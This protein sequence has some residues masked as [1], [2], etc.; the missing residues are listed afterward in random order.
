MKKLTLGFLALATALATPTVASATTLQFSGGVNIKDNATD[1]GNGDFWSTSTST[2]IGPLHIS[3][4]ASNTAKG[5]GGPTTVLGSQ[6]PAGSPLVEPMTWN[7]TNGTSANAGDVFT[8]DGGLITFLV[9]GS[10]AVQTDTGSALQFSGTGTWMET[11]FTNTP[12]SFI[13]NV[14]DVTGHFGDGVNGSSG[15]QWTLNANPTPEPS[16]LILLGTG[17]LGLAFVAFRKAKPAGLTLNL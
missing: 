10:I 14:N 2:Q 17:L 6:I 13:Y 5:T 12:G 16:S 4:A 8:L 3:P 7:I 11:G 1:V 15:G 9:T